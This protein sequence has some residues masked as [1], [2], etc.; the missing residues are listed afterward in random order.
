M[1]LKT[2]CVQERTESPTIAKKLLLH[3]T[4]TK[5]FYERK[6]RWKEEGWKEG[7]KKG[8]KEGKKERRKREGRKKGR[9]KERKKDVIDKINISPMLGLCADLTNTQCW[10]ECSRLPSKP[11]IALAKTWLSLHLT[12]PSHPL[13]K[14]GR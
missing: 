2:S 6:E 13:P 4:P 7:R 5:M 14:L 11:V 8:K 1:K 3:T 12:A 10:Q 9:K